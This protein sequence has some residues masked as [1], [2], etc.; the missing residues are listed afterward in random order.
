MRSHA[1]APARGVRAW[2]RR[3]LPYPIAAGA[4]A[5][6]FSRYS[7]ADIAREVGKGQTLA[8]VPYALL[9]MLVNLAFVSG[10]DAIVLRACA[11]RPGWPAVAVG[12]PEPPSSAPS[13]T[14]PCTEVT[15]CG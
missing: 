8:V 4:I 10:A 2:L 5:A 7:P 6:V 13:A 9:V 14:R 15:G 11:G 3:V 1:P 12:R